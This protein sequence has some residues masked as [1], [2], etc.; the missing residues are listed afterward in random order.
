MGH[1]VSSSERFITFQKI[2]NER[3]ICI[4]KTY[5]EKLTAKISPPQKFQDHDKQ[6]QLQWNP[7]I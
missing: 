6:V 1:A 5:F 3:I 4:L 2:T 7:A